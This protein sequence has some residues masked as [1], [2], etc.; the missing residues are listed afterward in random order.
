[1]RL[2]EAYSQDN[3]A[4]FHVNLGPTVIVFVLLSA[5]AGEEET[6]RTPAA[7]QFRPPL[8]YDI[9]SRLGGDFKDK[10]T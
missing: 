6:G 8:L 9:P 5:V 10:A 2:A 3:V 7:R 4:L 1:M